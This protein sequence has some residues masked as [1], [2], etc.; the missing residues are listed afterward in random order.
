MAGNHRAI[1]RGISSLELAAENLKRILITHA[2][3][4]HYGALARLLSIAGVQTW[5]SQPEAEA[6][7]AGH[8]SRDLKG[9]S[10]VEKV[11]VRASGPMMRAAPAAID[12]LLMPG[13]TLPILGGLVVIDSRGHTPGHISFFLPEKRVLF[14]G[15]S[16]FRRDGRF[17]PSYGINCWDEELAVSAMQVQLELAP[18]IICGGHSVFRLD[19]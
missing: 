14:S 19:S 11:F 9:N 7:I 18:K 16:I 1:L 13:E 8:A 17:I 10:V 12:R 5:T 15:D 4:D 2:D 6:I 3:S